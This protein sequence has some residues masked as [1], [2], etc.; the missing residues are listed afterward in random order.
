MTSFPQKDIGVCVLEWIKGWV[1]DYELA[2]KHHPIQ[3]K[4]YI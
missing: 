1:T 2:S 3:H 4:G